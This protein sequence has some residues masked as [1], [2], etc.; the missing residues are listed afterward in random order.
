MAQ[1]TVIT[2]ATYAD[3]EAV[4]PHLVAEIIGGRLVTHPRPRPRHARAG[5]ALG[6]V[7]GGA[8]DWGADAPGGWWILDEPELHFGRE[9]LVPDIAGWQRCRMPALPETAWFDLAPDWVCEI[10]SPSTA[11]YDRGEKRDT[12]AANGVRHL[13][14][15]DPEVRQIEVFEL[16]GGKWLLLATLKGEDEVRAAPFE[17][18]GLRL[19]ALWAD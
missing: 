8:F 14:L 1:D 3:L 7:I 13:W 19:K 4:P 5:S 2:R 10:L 12:Y 9:V 15:V 17:E 18:L 6:G 16:T 11:T